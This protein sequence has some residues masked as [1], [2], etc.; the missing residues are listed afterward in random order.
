MR[1]NWI[2]VSEKLPETYKTILFYDPSLTYGS[3]IETNFGFMNESGIWVT[4][5]GFEADNVTHWAEMPER[6]NV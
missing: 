3:L 2:S 5:D 4:L 1:P 6:P